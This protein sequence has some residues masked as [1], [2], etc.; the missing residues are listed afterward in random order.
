MQLSL[1][2]LY[3]N[4]L[5]QANHETNMQFQH[6]ESSAIVIVLQGNIQ[7]IFLN[8]GNARIMSQ[9]TSVTA[10]NTIALY[11]IHVPIHNAYMYA[12]ISS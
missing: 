5:F 9:E 10:F 12:Y 6:F 11:I 3:S 8:P 1:I 2:T 4:P 7:F